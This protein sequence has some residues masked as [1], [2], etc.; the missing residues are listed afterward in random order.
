[1]F[2]D[3]KIKKLIKKMIAGVEMTKEDLQFYVNNA[4]QIERRLAEILSETKHNAG[5]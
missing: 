1:M 4:E 5:R 2:K 3:R